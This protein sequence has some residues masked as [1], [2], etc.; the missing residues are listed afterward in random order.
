[1]RNFL[2]ILWKDLVTEFRTKELLSAMFTFSLLILLIF[3]F[4][5]NFSQEILK[6]STPSI[7]WISFTFAGILG[8]GRS[9]AVEK[10]GNA[11]LG[12]L[13]TPIDRSV[14]YFGKMIGNLIFVFIVELISL[15]LFVLFFNYSLSDVIL[16]LSFVIVLGTIGFVSV[17]TIFSAIA[18]N[19]KL[20]EVLL[21]ILIFPII[22][23]VIVSSVQLTAS[24][25]DGNPILSNDSNLRILVSFDIIFIAACA[26]FFEFV[27]EE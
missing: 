22:I 27:L 18:L 10:E 15:G 5:F 23:P 21:P 13:L 4:S 8:L 7:L 12:L 6:F 1:M 14:L 3:N 11:I 25:L 9:F 24:I 20:R 19:T 16:P 17:G 26:V 2:A